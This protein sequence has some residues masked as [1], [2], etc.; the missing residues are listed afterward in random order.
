VV[1][2]DQKTSKLFKVAMVKKGTTL[3]VFGDVNPYGE[4]SYRSTD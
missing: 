2:S 4:I 3:S 1:F